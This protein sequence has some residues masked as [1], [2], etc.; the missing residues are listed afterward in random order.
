MEPGRVHLLGPYDIPGL[1]PR[2]FVRVYVPRRARPAARPLLFLFDGQNA[3]DDAPSFAGGWHA[4]L[5]VERLASVVSP[6]VVLALDHGNAHRIGELSP[7]EV[8]SG[9]FVGPGHA[10]E[11][12]AWVAEHLL[13]EL[14]PRLAID[15]DPRR[16]VVGGSS[17]GGLAALYAH[18]ARP[19]VFG[20]AVSMS[21][22]L[23]V[24][25]RAT[26]DW[27]KWRGLAPWSRVYLDAGRREARGALIREVATL[28]DLLRRL[29]GEHVWFRDDPKGMHHEACWRRRLP[30]ALR[31]FF[32]KAAN[33]TG[34]TRA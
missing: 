20:G 9:P 21:P 1:A 29:G 2:R 28:A 26:F 11:L 27:V 10:P 12:L 32:G 13:P 16:A 25:R 5:A 23:W 30:R 14:R 6:P 19:D 3:F 33:P 15:P 8:T 4:H 7:F 17:M 22:S 18:V 34:A 24:A 31:H